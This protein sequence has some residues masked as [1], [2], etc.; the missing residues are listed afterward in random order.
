MII[1]RISQNLRLGWVQS[2]LYGLVLFFLWGVVS[3][4]W[5]IIVIS[6]M[7]LLFN[8]GMMCLEN[9]QDQDLE[10]DDGVGI[11]VVALRCWLLIFG[12][13]MLS[14]PFY[15]VTLHAHRKFDAIVISLLLFWWVLEVIGFYQKKLIIRRLQIK[16]EIKR[17]SGLIRKFI[18][19]ISLEDGAGKDEAIGYYTGIVRLRGEVAEQ[20]GARVLGMT[21][22]WGALS[23]FSPEESGILYRRIDYLCHE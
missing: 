5:L 2:L 4:Q 8:L 10:H 16:W 18:K 23:A 11:D 12:A 3:W 22:M 20:T 19:S 13:F 9:V 14:G 7:R 21:N 15:I 17:V 6:I 1:R